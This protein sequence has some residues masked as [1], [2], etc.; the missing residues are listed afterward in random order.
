MTP[1]SGIQTRNSKVVPKRPTLICSLAS[2]TN[3]SA[4]LIAPDWLDPRRCGHAAHVALI[5]P[6][7]LDPRGCVHAA[8]VALFA[9][10]WLDPRSCGHTAHLAVVAPA[11]LDPRSCGH[12]A[13][14]A[15][16]APAWLDLRSCEHA[17]RLLHHTTFETLI[18]SI[19]I[20]RNSELTN[21]FVLLNRNGSFIN[22][23]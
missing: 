10:A 13:Y 8:H 3:A 18:H 4:R 5:A 15:L 21:Y 2:I 23:V 9:P 20:T 7:W 16:I 19:I 22:I 12:A 1:V 6:A 11:S 17:A 14:V